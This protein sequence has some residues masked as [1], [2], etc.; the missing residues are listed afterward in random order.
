MQQQNQQPLSPEMYEAI[1]QELNAT[2]SNLNLELA[3]LRAQNKEIIKYT[4]EL[5]KNLESTKEKKEVE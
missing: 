1:I 2:M 4:Q 3:L 5:E